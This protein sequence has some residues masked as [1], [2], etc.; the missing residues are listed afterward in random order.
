MNLQKKQEW[1]CY[2][3]SLDVCSVSVV[4]ER[5]KKM[6]NN[7]V[8]VGRM[9]KDAELKAKPAIV[10]QVDNAGSEMVGTVT[11]KEV[12]QGRYTLTIGAYGKFLVTEQQYY[13]TRIGDPIPE[14]LKGHG[15]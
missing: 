14:F 2:G 8:L 12:I 13:E 15:N 7:V 4:L 11:D 5:T 1:H 6:I 9:T 10:Y 3:S